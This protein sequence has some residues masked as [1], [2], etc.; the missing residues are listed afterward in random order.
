M[1]HDDF[2][3]DL[4]TN[5]F[6]I[7][8]S[9]IG[10]ETISSLI[11]VIER[12]P[13][14]I[15][16]RLRNGKPFAR[17]N[18]LQIPE[19][20]ALA[21]SPAVKSVVDQVLGEHSVPIRGI[22]FDKN[23]AANWVVPWHQDLSIAVQQRVDTPGFGPW[24]QKAGLFHVQPPIDVLQRMLTMRVHL[25]D[26]SRSNGP[27]RVIPGSHRRILNS[28]ELARLVEE[29]REVSCVVPAGGVLVMRP[30]IVHASSPA[31]NVGRRRV[32]HL[33]Y[34]TGSLPGN[35]RWHADQNSVWTI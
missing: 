22:F 15:S 13:N 35:L 28:E 3:N 8:N 21:N 16:S 20:Y 30:L 11:G 5:G 34:S 24:S 27:L 29:S 18:L 19:I 14:D 23:S 32:I 12:L 31:L 2:I 10:A 17:R 1:Q 6:A 33:E 9:F 26:C 25:D 4:E 7:L